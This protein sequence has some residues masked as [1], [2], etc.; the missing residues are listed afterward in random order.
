MSA[1]SAFAVIVVD[2]DADVRDALG[3]LLRTVG[4]EVTAFADPLS[5]LNNDRGFERACLLFD[6]RIPGMS[7]LQMLEALAARNE[8]RPVLIMSGHADVNAC[9]RAFKGG[10]IDFLSKPIDETDLI[11]AVLNAHARFEAQDRLSA[12]RRE[13]AALLD[14]L[15]AR[16]KEVLDMVVK[17]FSTREIAEAL[18]VS[19]RTIDTHRANIGEKLGTTSVAEM[20]RLVLAAPPQSHP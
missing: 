6:V 14:S 8:Q 13:S 18:A 12:E 9:R 17:G 1:P 4:Y 5:F 10:A 2:D 11:E 7:G 16:E 3:L 15:T 20:A 19:P